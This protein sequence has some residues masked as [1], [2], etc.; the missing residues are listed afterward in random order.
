LGYLFV[1]AGDAGSDPQVLEHGIDPSDEAT[2]T[3]LR[4]TSV[5]LVQQARSADLLDNGDVTATSGRQR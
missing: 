4:D 1:D 5:R 2:V 3:G